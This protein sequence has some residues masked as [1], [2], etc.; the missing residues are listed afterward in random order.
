[1][2]RSPLNG[3]LAPALA[4]LLGTGAVAET[5]PE[6]AV[7]GGP[8]LGLML[9]SDRARELP[10][11]GEEA[12][13]APIVRLEARWAEIER[14]PGTYD[15]TSTAPAIDSLRSAGYRTVLALT[16]SH[17]AYLPDGGPPSPLAGRSL[18]AWIDFVR[19]AARTFAGRVAV[20][21]LGDSRAGGS[22][23]EAAVDALVLK[24]SA[25]AVRAE[26]GAR[27]ADV[28]IA[29]GA[30]PVG[31]LEWQRAL[32]ERDLAAY[33]DVL[34]LIVDVEPDLDERALRIRTVLEESL[35]HP[36]APALWAYVRGG[37]GWDAPGL[38]VAAL[39]S[40]AAAAF[41]R[42]ADAEQIRWAGGLQETLGRGFA[43]TILGD[44]RLEYDPEPTPARARVLGRFF[45]AQDF[46]TLV[47]Y[48]AP[49]S[50]DVPVSELLVVDTRTV[51]D[52]RVLD[53]MT[54]KT[55]R[56]RNT[57]A[58]GGKR[59]A[60]HVGS[61]PAPR[62]ALFEKQVATPGFEMPAED[63]EVAGERGLTAEEI[64]AR[65]QLLQRDQDDRLE[66]WMAD[67]RID[68][69]FKL[70]QSGSTVDVSIDCHYFWERGG[71]LEWEQTGY[72]INGNRVGWK[73]M[74]ELPLIQPDKVITLPLDLTLDKTYAYR[75][76]GE[77]RVGGRDAYVLAFEPAIPDETLSLYR[78]RIWIDKET[79]ARVKASV[80]QSNLNPPVLSNEEI[81]RFALRVGPD[82]QPYWMFEKIDGQQIW[83]TAG[84][85]FVVL[86]ELTFSSFEIN[87]PRAAFEDRRDRAYASP[88]QMLRDTDAGFRYLQRQ[89]DGS[90]AV[91][92]EED[93]TQIF[94][95]GG[96]FKDE[97]LDNVVPLAGVNY[98]DYDLWGKNIQFNALFAG[99]LG[100]VT[101]SKPSLGGTRMDIAADVRFNALKMDDKVYEGDDEIVIERLESRRQNLVLRF[102]V[103]AGQ[104]VKFSFAAGLNYRQ[105]FH[106]DDADNAL[107]A[108]NLLQGANLAFVLPEDHLQVT[109]TIEVELNRRGYNLT[110]AYSRATRSDWKAWGLYDPE[111]GFGTIVGDTFV[112]TGGEAIQDDFARWRV[113]TS[114]EW[115]LPK[116]Q[117]IRGAVDYLNGSDLDRFSRYEFSYFGD[118]RL[119][120]FSG[121]GVRFD[122]GVIGRIGYSFNL[123]EVIRL[124]AALDSA[125]VE[126]DDSGV[127]TQSFTGIGL[128]GNFV[129]PWK[130]VISLGYGQ[131]ISSDIA[132]LEG[133]GEFLLLVLKLF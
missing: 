1:M 52:V 8:S 75:L 34:P 85:T 64:I 68:F 58:G 44:L 76:S 37:S 5:P 77:D 119:N 92:M 124:D 43:P 23:D 71:H 13:A 105:F 69:H 65:Y 88:N 91:K 15:W 40:G 114:K 53:P 116:F 47:V 131:A 97:S 112:A 87:P 122:E 133:D 7:G 60:L 25:L 29:Q 33:F 30:L 123:F 127:G 59:R 54:G 72:Y 128:S 56:I 46:T 19:S 99:V 70:A 81:D 94:A 86:R 115:Y 95:A 78:G 120:G 132:D 51:R 93:T 67:G 6:L 101:A 42:P 108:Y 2:P 96:A 104:F 20:F 12:G 48:H 111:E 121:S 66:R 32:W 102:G 129:G 109:G 11:V 103:P 49:G 28:R 89:D 125:R 26:A 3:L 130:T 106:A 38:A 73:R 27:G 90:R 57:P 74:P 10:P 39:T 45:N 14:V 110:G 79:F 36:P 16:G 100:F 31:A 18:E 83:N 9:D 84:R 55:R 113:S 22:D 82:G 126:E 107:E 50:E 4:C 117:K 61:A 98:F 63:L 62:A 118:D 80:I 41:F 17:P 35:R 21:E 24:Q